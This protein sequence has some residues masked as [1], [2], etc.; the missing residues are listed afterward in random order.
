[1]NAQIKTAALILVT[2]VAIPVLAQTSTSTKAVEPSMQH[3]KKTEPVPAKDKE[4]IPKPMDGMAGMNHSKMNHSKMDHVQPPAMP[5]MNHGKKVEPKIMEGM[6]HSKMDH[7][8]PSA[9]P[10]KMEHKKKEAPLA[11]DGMDHQNM[12]PKADLPADGTRNPHAYSGGYTLGE[13]AYALP[14]SQQL[15]LADEKSFASFLANKL[16][17]GLGNNKAT[18]YDTQASFG[19]D[20]DRVTVKA[21]GEISKS[22][23]QD[24]RTELLWGHAIAPFWDTQ[25]GV[26]YDKGAVPSQGWLAMGVQGI[27]PYWFEIDAT[28]YIGNNGKTAL[29][30]GAEY[31]ILLSQKLILQPSLGLNLYGKRD[32]AR[33]IGSGLNSATAGLRLRYEI[34]RQFAPYIGVEHIKK[35]GETANIASAA[36]ERTQETRWVAGTRIWF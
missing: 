32:V 5:T 9:M 12:K 25:L 15:K 30:L 33:D 29:R 22:K 11:M 10:P 27:A 26:R 7:A 19:R 6:D 20:Y 13:G 18:S 17:R 1:M 21:E 16:E 35:L 28:A 3:E 2:L 31:E 36:G 4:L 23:L 8:T 14:A 24:S 34:T